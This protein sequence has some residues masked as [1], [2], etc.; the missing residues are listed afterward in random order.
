MILPNTFRFLFFTL[1]FYVPIHLSAQNVEQQFAANITTV[2]LYEYGNQQGMPVYTIN[3]NA[4]LELH[5][6]DMDGGYKNYYFT[7]VLCDYNWKPSNL[8]PFDFMKGFNQNRISTYRYSNLAFTRYTHYQAKLPDQ[9]SYPIRSGNYLLKV[10]LDGDTS[11]VVFTKQM[12]VVEPKSV[13]NAFVVQP[14]GAQLFKTHQRIRFT[15]NIKDINSFSAAQQVKAVVLQNNRWD[16]AQRDITPAFVRGN[17]LDFNMENAAVF[18]AG[19]EWR[20]LD[21]RS[22]R[23][24]SDRVDHG[25]YN[26]DKRE[27][28]LKNDE[29]RSEQRYAYFPDYNGMYNIV[30]Y[31]TLNPLFQG[32]YANVHFYYA[33]NDVLSLYKKK[34]YL[35][36]QFTNYKINDKW[37]MIYNPESGLY[38]CVVRLKQGYYNYTFTTVGEEG[39]DTKNELEGNYWETENSYTVL[40]YYKSFTDRNDRLIGIANINSR[41][42][43]PGFSF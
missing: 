6:D 34:L 17:V 13:V 39:I 20:W 41:T 43:K 1:M 21:L 5:F 12:L 15:A 42:D 24:L 14:F 27:I 40:I 29:S 26:P 18:P 2:Q 35:Q 3:G 9:N 16:L 30:T 38:E 25:I 11:K 31:E 23:L 37:E 19:K 22:F 10:Y 28:Y 7:Y 36:G 32:D 33:S 4:Q 8:S